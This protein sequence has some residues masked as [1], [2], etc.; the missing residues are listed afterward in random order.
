MYG[1]QAV[2]QRI[3][4]IKNYQRQPVLQISKHQ[5]SDCLLSTNIS[6][7][8]RLRCRIV[9]WASHIT[10]RLNRRIEKCACVVRS[11]RTGNARGSLCGVP[12]TTMK[13]SASLHGENLTI[14]STP[15]SMSAHHSILWVWHNEINCSYVKPQECLF[16]KHIVEWINK[17]TDLPNTAKHPSLHPCKSKASCQ[18]LH[19]V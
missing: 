3:K 11:S 19:S 13:L 5:S 8:I 12:G 2:L 9:T 1:I 16:L 15:E 4:V 6:K 14:K 10:H 7:T 17:H 18:T